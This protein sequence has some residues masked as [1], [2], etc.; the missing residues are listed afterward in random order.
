M[1]D[2]TKPIPDGVEVTENVIQPGKVTFLNKEAI[3]NPAPQKMKRI[4]KALNYFCV[5]L[6]TAVGGSDLFSGGQAKVIVF[7]IG[8]FLLAIGSL[9]FLTGV[10]PVDDK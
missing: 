8:V 3:N 1:P 2:E 7:V 5:G 6:M 9:E 10:K 4:I